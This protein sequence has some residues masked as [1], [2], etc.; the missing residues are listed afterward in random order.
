M[1]IERINRLIAWAEADKGAHLTMGAW[2]RWLDKPDL[3]THGEARE[4]E[5]VRVHEHCQTA[6]CLCG[7]AN[8]LRLKDAGRID[9][10]WKP[11]YLGH[12]PY[13]S[14]IGDTGAARDW[15][16]LNY[17]QAD[18]LF[19]MDV[20]GTNYSG[21]RQLFDLLPGETKAS[22]IIVLL[23]RLKERESVDWQTALEDVIG[24][25]KTE[26]MMNHSRDLNL[27]SFAVLS[28]EGA[29]A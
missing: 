23:K 22:V 15:L 28:W 18:H 25:A 7:H 29:P 14:E 24:V 17:L 9:Q 19:Y 2:V 20:E 3:P 13:V 6:Y 12:Q 11:D 1:N 8:Y 26:F 21:M 4:K 16:D 5:P 27:N 10:K